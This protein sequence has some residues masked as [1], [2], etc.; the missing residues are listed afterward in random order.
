MTEEQIK[1]YE[2]QAKQLDE[3]K[4]IKD[5]KSSKINKILIITIVIILIWVLLLSSNPNMLIIL[6]L[7]ITYVFCVASIF[8]LP[9][10]LV[11]MLKKTNENVK[12]K[13]V[14]KSEI[15][16][17]LDVIN[18]VKA[19]YGE[20]LV[21]DT[22]NTILTDVKLYPDK[23]VSK[24]FV[25]ELRIIDL[26]GIYTSKNL[27]LAKYEGIDIMRVD[28]NT[29]FG[30]KLNGEPDYS[31]KGQIFGFSFNKEFKSN[32][33]IIENNYRFKSK[34]SGK[35]LIKLE[36]EEFNNKFEVIAKNTQ[37]AYYILTPHFME[38][39]KNLVDLDFDKEDTMTFFF[40]LNRLY[41]AVNN[42]KDSFEYEDLEGL[43][44]EDFKDLVRKEIKRITHIIDELS[45]DNNLFK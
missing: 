31:F 28:V 41:I 24:D 44:E 8:L 2:E 42:E 34:E 27:M 21:I 19:S 11:W 14:N 10:L 25:R 16:T 30:D 20:T 17:K 29:H 6:P 3:A 32:I 37:E 45:L 38:K 36:D 33:R 40:D 13:D 1:E 9:V 4:K 23:G 35:H 26:S 22:L 15:K 39:M 7:E 12:K 18:K 5:K 43:S